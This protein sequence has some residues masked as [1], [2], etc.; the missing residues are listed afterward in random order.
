MAETDITEIPTISS[1][2]IKNRI[3][4]IRGVQVMLD[5]DLAVLYGVE[6]KRINEVVKR[7]PKRFPPSFA[8]IVAADEISIIESRSQNA[9]TIMQK[10][11]HR[12]EFFKSFSEIP[13]MV[14]TVETAPMIISEKT[15]LSRIRFERLLY[16]LYILII[17]SNSHDHHMILSN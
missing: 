12:L 11:N 13:S 15:M 2:D 17:F 3:Y 8:F 10:R 7:N 1:D 9:T 16:Q 14:K 5:S 4:T 6:T